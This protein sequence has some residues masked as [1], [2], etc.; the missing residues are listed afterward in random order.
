MGKVK[1]GA[2]AGL[3]AGLVYGALEA[4][5]VVAL[6]VTFRSRII[7]VIRSELPS[8]TTVDASAVYNSLVG[9]DAAIAVVFGIIAGMVLGLVFGAVSDRI[10]GRRGATK[11][12]VFG[13]VLWL[14]LHVV[15]DYVENLKYGVT[16]YLVDI[17][18]GLGTSLVYGGLLGLFFE[19]E[20]KR[21][22]SLGKVQATDDGGPIHGSPAARS[23]PTTPSGSEGMSSTPVSEAEGNEL[24]A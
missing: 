19:R 2:K 8:G 6:L 13:L 1:G 10:P 14:I 11:G 4:S 15:A 3:L 9:V 12:L 16:F 17:G 23:Q 21:L 24:H 22:P 18:L 7:D 5:V 20:M